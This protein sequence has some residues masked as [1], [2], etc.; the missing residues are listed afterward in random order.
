MAIDSTI[1]PKRATDYETVFILRGDIDSETSERVIS[2]AVGAVESTG[3]RLT[4]VESWGKRRLAYPIAKQRRGFYVL[5]R[6][7][8][9]QGTVSEVERNLRMLDPVVRHMT[10]AL[11]KGLDPAT[12]TVDPE[13]IKVR[14]IEISPDDDDKEESVE[15]LL[16]LSEDNAPPRAPQEPRGMDPNMDQAPESETAAAAA[17]PGSTPVGD[18]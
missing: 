8:G 10:V 1:D 3:G 18:A 14:R 6:Y 11:A 16:G 17:G 2:R 7:L 13:E 9:Y 4:K 12:I 5:V 15:A